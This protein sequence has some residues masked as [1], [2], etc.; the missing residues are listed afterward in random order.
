MTGVASQRDVF[1]PYVGPGPDS[2]CTDYH[3]VAAGQRSSRDRDNNPNSVKYV[4]G[5]GSEYGIALQL[6]NFS[7]RQPI[8]INAMRNLPHSGQTERDYEQVNRRIAQASVQG[9]L[10]ARANI[11]SGKVWTP[12]TTA[13]TDQLDHEHEQCSRAWTA[14]PDVWYLRKYTPLPTTLIQMVLGY[15]KPSRNAFDNLRLV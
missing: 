3:A 15:G 13:A 11:A 5:P 12:A 1:T 9:E 7:Q 8:V 6:S 4:E 10:A 14:M 2:I